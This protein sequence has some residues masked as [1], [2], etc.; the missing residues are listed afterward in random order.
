M[1]SRA[2]LASR[3]AGLALCLMLCLAGP[4][5]ASDLQRVNEFGSEGTAPGQIRAN[6]DDLQ[7]TPDGNLAVADAGNTRIQIF[8]PAGGLV[9]AFGSSGT[10]PG[11][12]A[13]AFGVAIHRDGSI[14]VEDSGHG[15]VE[16]FGADGTFQRSF[17]T[18][19]DFYAGAAL[20]PGNTIIYLVDYQSGNVQRLSTT[21]ANMGVFGSLGSGNGQFRR[22]FGI[23]VD[24]GGNIYV[25]DRDNNRVEKLSPSGAFLAHIGTGAGS[26]PGQM[27]G[28]ED[29]AIEPDGKV[30]VADTNNRRLEEFT[31]AGQFLAS[32]DRIAGSPTA[33]F[34]PWAVT[35]SPSGD[36]YLFDRQAN[37]PRLVRVRAGAATPGGP[38]PVL[39]KSV[40]VARV[41]GTV[42]VR[43]RGAKKFHRLGAADSIPVGSSVDTQKGRV[44]LTS[45]TQAGGTQ[46]ADFFQG[47][48]KVGQ[49][50]SGL[51]DLK[52][53]GN[54]GSCA[55]RA[56]NGARRKTRRLWGRGT[57]QFRTT[58]HNGSATVRGTYW[59]VEDRCDG[60]LTKVKEGI[61]A[62]RD[63]TRR[64]TV[65]L[66]AGQQYLA[67]ARR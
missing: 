46:T 20:D 57:G 22:P 62:V 33:D 17:T 59:L 61:V 65:L 16:V 41:S 64:R 42:L 2:A 28:P 13:T 31:A 8:T 14:F 60:T 27:Q 54:L 67:P 1:G 7:V 58:G 5:T 53:E 44:R 23:A 30:L 34:V 11:Q 51:T 47:R 39:A 24:A 36:I 9:R 3:L 66:H 40:T 37:A 12:F 49:A 4:G 63:F 6:V 48:F 43:E 25:A 55:R 19:V 15:R 18:P 29:V 21:G 35:A 32:Y 52:L 56:A 45:A 50:R 26:G 38:A 10:G